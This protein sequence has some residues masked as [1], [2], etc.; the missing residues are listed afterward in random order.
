MTKFYTL[1]LFA[2]IAN[3]AVAQ[4][5]ISDDDLVAGGS[6]TWT[7]DK[8]Y[9][10]NG[11]V[12]LEEG[13]QLTIEAGTVIKGSSV[14]TD[15]SKASALIITKGA[16]IFAE[17]TAEKPIIFTSDLDGQIQ[18]GKDNKGAWGGVIILGKGIV[19]VDGGTQNIE[20]IPSTEGRAEYGGNDNSDN[21]GVLRYVS[22]RHAGS[23]LEANNEINGLT[24]GGVG[25]GTV[26]DY[27]EVFA[28]AD[29]GIEF[30]GGAVAVK[31]AVVSFCGDD[32]Y[33]YDQSW[34]GSGQYW[35]SLQD[36]ISNRAGE[37]DGS[38]ASDL[39]PSVS[40]VIAN[41]TFIGAGPVST[42][43]D[44]ND[45]LR[46]RDAGAVQLYNSILTGFAKRAIVLDNDYNG[47]GDSY[48][49]FLAGEVTFTGNIFENF[50]AGNTLAE[51]ISTDKGDDQLLVD[52]LVANGNE[53]TASSIGGI[54]RDPDGKLDPRVSSFR[55][56]NGAKT[57]NKPGID[58]V[59]YVGAFDNNNNWALGWTA[60]DKYGYFGNLVSTA[61]TGTEVA[62]FSV[63]PNPT[64]DFVNIESEHL[65]N[66]TVVVY[67][68]NGTKVKV[69]KVNTSAAT[70]SMNV[71]DLAAGSYFS[72]IVV[73]GK[74]VAKANFNK[75]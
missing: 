1:L 12:F 42:N 47:N 52:H 56:L 2:F 66:A 51:I 18:L 34:D 64:T 13:G 9:I 4:V 45:A 59:N 58:E 5:T 54:S 49:R 10:L 40:P 25:S 23:V 70:Y 48:D 11:Y 73:E 55:A 7:A 32:S 28:N 17:G 3:L 21:S 37:W 39:Q 31:H 27:V 50:A 57:V 63:Y 68:S 74:I 36:S 19:G 67:T 44:G 8:E 41:C 6:Y 46:I 15:G 35:F 62:S 14:P 65:A 53:L 33:D 26:I 72:T 16:K 43:K 29:D 69:E 24:L 20:G 75:Q 30:F 22:I 61:T 60:L 71:S 38:E